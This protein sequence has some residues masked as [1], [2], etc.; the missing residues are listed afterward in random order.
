[1]WSRIILF[2]S[3][4]EGFSE[5]N[6]ETERQDR[7]RYKD[8]LGIEVSDRLTGIQNTVLLVL[9]RFPHKAGVRLE[10]SYSLAAGVWLTS[11][12]SQAERSLTEMN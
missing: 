12:H 1:V 7:Y 6:R 10:W 3:C 8:I 11:A 5:S 9:A 2:I 4:N